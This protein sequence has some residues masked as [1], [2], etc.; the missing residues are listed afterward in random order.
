MS[1]APDATQIERLKRLAALPDHE[2]DTVDLPVITD[3]SRGIRGGTPREVREKVAAAAE[4]RAPESVV[5]AEWTHIKSAKVTYQSTTRRN[6]Y[7]YE[8]KVGNTVR[9][10]G[11]TQDPHRREIEYRLLWP[12]GRL[13]ILCPAMSARAAREWEASTD[14]GSPAARS[15]K[16]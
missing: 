13:V 2:I 12:A 14:W 5:R 7:R 4:Q 3:W 1:K 6:W 16:R 8:F 10:A 11:I 9:H 15:H